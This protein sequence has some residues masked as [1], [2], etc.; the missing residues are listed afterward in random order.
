MGCG[1]LRRSAGGGWLYGE[2]VSPDAPVARL[3]RRGFGEPTRSATLL[4]SLDIEVDDPLVEIV[5][6]AADPDL[7]L[8]YL[9]RLATPDPS[10]LDAVRADETFA[11]T[12]T[13]VLGAS[14]ALG[15]HLVRNPKDWH[16]LEPAHL[17]LDKPSPEQ[18]EG[19]LLHA[20]GA[21][22]SAPRG[23][24]V[25]LMPHDD[26]L[27]EL[28]LAY[29][30]ELLRIAAHDLAFGLDV[31]EVATELADLAA[32]S[33][34]AALAIARA[35]VGPDQAGA[36][37]AI[38][39]MG[40]CGGRELNYV[41]DVDVVFVG[42]PAEGVATRLAEGVIAA[43][44]QLTSEGHLF[45]V[46]PNLRPEGR[47]GPL[48][49]TLASHRAYYE[50][51]ART[52]EFQAL[53]KARAVAGDTELGTEYEQTIAPFVW[54]AAGREN[55]VA[56]VR[57]MRKRVLDSI[58]AQDADRELKLGPGGLRDVE[59][60]VQ[61]LQLV[62]G[63]DDDSLRSPATLIA[64]ASLSDGGYIGRDD[65]KGLQA[66]YK[67]L[68]RA[69]HRIQLQRLRRTHTVP[70]E[71]TSLRQLAR[72][73][74]YTRDAVAGFEADRVRHAYEIRRIHE[75]LFYRP[76]L[77]SV[78]RLSSGQT[79]LGPEQAAAR[80]AAL[81]FRDTRG[82][83][84]HLEA[85]SSG[86][87]RR[88]AIQRTL[89]PV[90]LG[91]FARGADP[92]AGLLA[93]RACS[94]ALGETPWYLRMLRD[95]GIAA[96]RLAIVLSSS[97]YVAEML[98]RSPEAISMLGFVEQLHPRSY[99]DIAAEMTSVARRND[100]EGAVRGVRSVRRHEL[101]RIACGD[102]LGELDQDTVQR[103]LT[104][105]ARATLESALGVALR[106]VALEHRGELPMTLAVI[107][108]G[109]LGGGE[110]SY[111]SDA[112]VLFVH[113]PLPGA[114]E[115]E[116]AKVAHDVAEEMR[117]LLALPA[118]DPA[119]L[120]DAGLRPEGRQGPLVR[121]IESYTEYYKRWSVPWEAQALLRAAPCAGDLQ[122]SA[123]FIE[124]INPLRWPRDLGED[125]VREMRRLKARMEAERMPRATD[126]TL[127]LKLG[128]GGLSDVEWTIQLMQLRAA[129]AHPELRTTSTLDAL[130]AAVE[131]GLLDPADGDILEEAWRGAARLRDALM[132]V[133]GRETEALPATVTSPDLQAVAH[134]VGSGSASELLETQRRRARRARAVVERL[135]FG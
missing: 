36:R 84:R 60:A 100:A 64:L 24:S 116:A 34:Q 35:Q 4:L 43:C 14:A 102:L 37:L 91:W 8:L 71:P 74:G 119:L 59:F 79:R 55:F 15:D 69:E 95:E 81:G 56:D 58:P 21:E 129:H 22:S 88:A 99:T 7:A 75:K 26:A 78:A 53:L 42:E 117:R 90:M 28:R 23:S 132:L 97:R 49:R 107:G 77:D 52:W 110:L 10:L 105:L 73:M 80:L 128:S 20:V 9:E 87:S 106:K 83:L 122:L 133:A 30:R 46:D 50:R 6:G 125:S 48:V 13:A 96:E 93:F 19:R 61:L 29:R 17:A 27:R 92:D 115:H 127:N 135:Y 103:A 33:L 11:R 5:A 16:L 65:A 101:L 118:P 113:R 45:P 94:D 18:L 124:L 51:W 57:S 130:R 63:R 108:M 72:A 44:S 89:L 111:A 39:A 82:S 41:S 38:I 32:A 70:S 67:F 47:M 3:A 31:E 126:R 109:R 2:G 12:L 134:V 62:H 76:L 66:S 131:V 121:S 123:D 98:T 104:D 68:R 114:L 40:K 1:G 25:S 120:I 112:D 86:V 85:L 54:T